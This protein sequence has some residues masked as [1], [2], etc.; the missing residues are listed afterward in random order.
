MSGVSDAQFLAM[1]LDWLIG[2]WVTVSLLCGAFLFIGYLKVK[3]GVPVWRSTN[4][5]IVWVL[6]VGILYQSF[7]D[8]NG[9]IVSLLYAFVG[10][11]IIRL[12]LGFFDSVFPPA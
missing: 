7:V 10:A 2:N 9:V 8:G 4:F 3:K 5:L 6:F 1:A 12:I 11:V